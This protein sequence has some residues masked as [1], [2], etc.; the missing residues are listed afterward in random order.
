MLTLDLEVRLFWGKKLTGAVILFF[1][2]RYTTVLYTI[3]HMLISL[4]PAMVATG[5]VSLPLLSLW[6]H[7]KLVL[8]APD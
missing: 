4:V 5:K 1:A 3:Y 6:E 2:N 7:L 8:T